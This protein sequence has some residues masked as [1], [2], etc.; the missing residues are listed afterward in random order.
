MTEQP[1][2]EHWTARQ[3]TAVRAAR[4]HA[5]LT[6]AGQ[7]VAVAESLTG[8][9]L[10]AALTATPGASGSFRGGLVVYATDLKAS[11]AGVA[12]R[13]LDGKGAVD[14]VVALELAR[15][16]R[17]RLGASWGI[18]VTGVAGPEPQDGKPVGTVFVA[19]VGPREAG[20]TVSE[21]TLAGSRNSIREQ[22][23]E[24]AVALLLSVLQSQPI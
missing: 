22:S 24:H 21:L 10:S 16:A 8:G 1:T 4:L 9:L 15:G 19:V 13:V 11:L 14:P 23:V 12:Q 3:S 18:G 5:A 20:E 17:T 2:T 7:T 6:A